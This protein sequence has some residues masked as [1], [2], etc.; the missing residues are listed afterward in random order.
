MAGQTG[1][2]RMRCPKI[3][4]D[5]AETQQRQGESKGE[6]LA[7]YIKSLRNGENMEQFKNKFRNLSSDEQLRFMRFVFT[8][9]TP[10]ENDQQVTA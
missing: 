6:A 5:I 4:H 3:L 2:Q 1:H 10:L 9:G 7:R 8:Q